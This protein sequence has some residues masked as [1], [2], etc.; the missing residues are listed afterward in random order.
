MNFYYDRLTDYI[1]NSNTKRTNSKDRANFKVLR[2]LLLILRARI[3]TVN[4]DKMP[5]ELFILSLD[6]NDEI[7]STLE[8][9]KLVLCAAIGKG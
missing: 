7:L 3:R 6:G 1:K 9:P 5:S 4:G 2:S 8:L